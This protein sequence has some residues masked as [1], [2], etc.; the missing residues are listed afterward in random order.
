[1]KSLRTLLSLAVA[2]LLLELSGLLAVS[3]PVE[4]SYGYGVQC[5]SLLGAYCYSQMWDSE[6]RS[7]YGVWDQFRDYQITNY[8]GWH[9]NNT[10]W[11]QA[12][13][14]SGSGGDSQC[15]V[16]TTGSL[17]ILEIGVCNGPGAPSNTCPVN[18]PSGEYSQYVAVG[19]QIVWDRLV[20]MDSSQHT[21]AIMSSGWNGS[22]Y[23]WQFYIDG[24]RP[25]VYNYCDTA[26]RTANSNNNAA[27]GG[28]F[29]N[30]NPGYGITALDSTGGFSNYVQLQYTDGS[31]H[32]WTNYYTYIIQP[33][34]SSGWTPPNCMNGANASQS[35]WNWNIP[36]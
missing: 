16:G 1:M 18:V 14:T 2:G 13:C 27:T 31:W 21:Y 25:S 5:Y 28:E 26:S 12:P 22:C 35:V 29:Q 9:I 23:P 11:L 33:C 7:I 15:G 3:V 36:G 19:G 32:A 6:N 10:L 30:G 8:D 17:V 4:A 20:P 34:Y 24:Q